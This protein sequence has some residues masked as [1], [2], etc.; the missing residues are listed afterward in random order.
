MT[1]C[2]LLY[3]LMYIKTHYHDQR[4]TPLLRACGRAGPTVSGRTHTDIARKL[5]CP[6][7]REMCRSE[8]PPPG[9][10]GSSPVR[11]GRRCGANGLRR[12]PSGVARH[13]FLFSK[14]QAVSPF[15]THRVSTTCIFLKPAAWNMA[16]SAPAWKSQTPT[17]VFF[18]N[19]RTKGEWW[20]VQ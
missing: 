17:V 16:S 8:V 14:T 1:K 11:G 20:S 13:P 3:H 9:R 18:L 5:N 2:V 12:A 7:G 4:S 10:R 6:H 19:P 15:A